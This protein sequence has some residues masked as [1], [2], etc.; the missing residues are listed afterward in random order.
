MKKISLAGSFLLSSFGIASSVQAQT[1]SE[2]YIFGDGLSD[3][4]NTFNATL[5]AF[6]EGIPPSPPFFQ[7]RFSNGPLWVEV[8]TSELGLPFDR[9]NNF[10]FAGATSGFDNVGGPLEDGDILELLDSPGLLGQIE[11]FSLANPIADPSGLYILETGADDYLSG[12]TNITTVITN[13]E[14]AINSL[15]ALGGRDI[16]VTNLPDLTLLPS[17]QNS[18]VAGNLP[19]LIQQHNLRLENTLNNLERSLSSEV[20]LIPFDLDSLFTEIISDP[21]QFNLTNVTDVCFDG[22]T[23]CENPDELFFWAGLNPSA[24][25]QQIIGESAFSTIQQANSVSVAEHTSGIGLLV[26]GLLSLAIGLA[27]GSKSHKNNT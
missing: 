18:N 6:G 12:Q 15:V 23:I 21:N 5:E 11:N 3:T 9:N 24:V 2:V 16:L 17:T 27:I 26:L 8:L 25:G 13:I 19:A 22:N 20:N 10:A 7:G 1:Y 14:T 4:G